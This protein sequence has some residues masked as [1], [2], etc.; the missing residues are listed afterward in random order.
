MSKQK[1]K[2]Q[3]GHVQT[4]AHVKIRYS[5]QTRFTFG[6]DTLEDGLERLK[7]WQESFPGHATELIIE[8]V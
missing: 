3:I 4:V 7:H 6:T 5:I 2:N 8:R 1:R